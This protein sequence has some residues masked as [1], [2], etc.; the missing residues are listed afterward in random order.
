M[1]GPLLGAQLRTGSGVPPSPACIYSPLVFLAFPSC[2]IL[3]QCLSVAF[4]HTRRQR[5]PA[6]TRREKQAGRTFPLHFPLS[7]LALQ[8]PNAARSSRTSHWSIQWFMRLFPWLREQAWPPGDT[9]KQE[10]GLLV[11][12]RER[13]GPA[14]APEG[15]LQGRE[16][17]RKQDQ[18]MW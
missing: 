17:G 18:E 9:S 15:G 4:S 5:E 14:A 1:L 12:S 8:D 11:S 10:A 3:C 16:E 13:S 7:S 6:G 2:L